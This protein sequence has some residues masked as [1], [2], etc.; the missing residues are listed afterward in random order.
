MESYD[1]DN[2]YSMRLEGLE[3][4]FNDLAYSRAIVMHGADYVSSAFV[5]TVGRLG[6]S[7]GCPAVRR[8]VARP[9]IDTIKDGQYLFAYYPDAAW[10]AGSAYLGCTARGV[11]K[12]G[13]RHA[14]AESG[15]GRPLGVS[16]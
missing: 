10:L 14:P 8:E 12:A 11:V 5:K 16:D 9:L 2:G 4:G 15:S 7:H 6:R 3:P 1:G 13:A